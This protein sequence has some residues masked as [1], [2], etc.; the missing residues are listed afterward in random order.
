MQKLRGNDRFANGKG[1]D[2]P[3]NA[4]FL[5]SGFKRQNLDGSI[6]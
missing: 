4:K 1:M 6:R 5:V 2:A 3:L